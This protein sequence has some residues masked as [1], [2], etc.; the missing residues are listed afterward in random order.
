MTRYNATASG[1]ES[2]TS[3]LAYD[4]FGRI[5]AETDAAGVTFEH[6]YNAA[7]DRIQTIFPA[8]AGSG[9]NQTTSILYLRSPYNTS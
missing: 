4:D 6:R 2:S 5:S 3:S 7:D 8:V 1:V 9:S